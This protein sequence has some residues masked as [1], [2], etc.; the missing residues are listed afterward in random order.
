M[1]TSLLF[2]HSFKPAAEEDL[3]IRNTYRRAD[4]HIPISRIRV[5]L[6]MQ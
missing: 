6:T 3:N 2:I 4:G 5:F 1:S